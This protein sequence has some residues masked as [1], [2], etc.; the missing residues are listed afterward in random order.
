MK[1][2]TIENLKNS[3]IFKNPLTFFVF[4]VNRWFLNIP[5]YILTAE[6]LEPFP[7]AFVAGEKYRPENET[8]WCRN[9]V[10]HVENKLCYW[11]RKM[12]RPH[13]F[14]C[15]NR[16]I[17]WDL[18]R[19]AERR[20]GTRILGIENL[21]KPW[22]GAT[23]TQGRFSIEGSRCSRSGEAERSRERAAKTLLDSM[24][25]YQCGSSIGTLS[26]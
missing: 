19:I 1:I 16:W 21:W 9:N 2:P 11:C 23:K 10:T 20:C 8:T 7:R 22:Q 4:K 3:Q 5:M 26:G 6:T 18:T 24:S 13:E 25:V 14:P 17:F 12:K 15:Q